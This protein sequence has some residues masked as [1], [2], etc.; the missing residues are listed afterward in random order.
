MPAVPSAA[1]TTT[2]G[3]PSVA[4]QVERL[5]ALGVPQL[6]GVSDDAF[7]AYGA[8]LVTT[9]SP[10]GE[11]VVVVHPD[12]AGPTRLAPLLRRGDKAGFV[13]VD[14]TDLD[15]FAPIDV[16]PSP[17]HPSTSTPASTAATT[18]AGPRPPRRCPSCSRGAAPR[19]R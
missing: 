14:L 17:T 6:A 10:Y 2:H 4:D 18:C 16:S 9:E 1:S 8:P 7:R 15:D 3:L 11:A 13:V 5:V 19:S 12:L